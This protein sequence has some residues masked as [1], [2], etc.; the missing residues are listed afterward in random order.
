MNTRN[1][2]WWASISINSLFTFARLPAHQGN[3]CFTLKDTDETSSCLFCESLDGKLNNL[4]VVDINATFRELTAK[5][6]HSV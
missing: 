4:I 2:P 5:F 1:G 6:Q 3:R